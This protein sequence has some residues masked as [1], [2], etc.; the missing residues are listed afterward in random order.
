VH[1]N[2]FVAATVLVLVAAASPAQEP[3]SR[4]AAV[5]ETKPDALRFALVEPD[6]Y[7]R[8]KISDASRLLNDG[9]PDAIKNFVALRKRIAAVAPAPESKPAETKPADP[10]AAP[11]APEAK[12]VDFPAD[13]KDLMSKTVTGSAADSEAALDSLKKKG[14]QAVPALRRL[15]ERSLAVLSR[16]VSRFVSTQ[17]ATNALFAGQY[18]DL[19]VYGPDAVVLL[20][21][22]TVE[23]PREAAEGSA[24]SFKSACVRAIR[25]LV[26]AAEGNDRLR[27]HLKSVVGRAQQSNNEDLMFQ[28]AAALK[29]YGDSTIFDEL[30]K[31]VETATKS[32]DPK[33]KFAGWK[34]LSELY[35]NARLYDDAC[36]A[37]MQQ[38]AAAEALKLPAQQMSSIQYNACCAHALAKKI[39]EAFALL[40][41][42][43]QGGATSKVT[44]DNDHDLTALRADPRF[45]ALMQKH[46]GAKAPPAR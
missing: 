32:D 38:I 44:I 16:L 23:P 20:A 39:D 25:D 9:G 12:P 40:E 34:A 30:K 2:A 26:P 3:A 6:G 46:F 8:P 42:A 7:R 15:D 43:L 24:E 27:Q 5:S 10:A 45:D 22:W 13:L 33:R 21:R 41:K 36:G 35:Y 18:D 28:A 4:P 1:S 14:D 17:I 11:A 31:N 29:Q 19:K 37:Y